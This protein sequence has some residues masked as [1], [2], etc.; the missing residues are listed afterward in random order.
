MPKRGKVFD[1]QNNTDAMSRHN[2]VLN[3]KTLK[4]KKKILKRPSQ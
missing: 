4:K 1:L 3:T 2:I